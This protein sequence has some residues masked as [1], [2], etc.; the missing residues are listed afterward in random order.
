MLSRLTERLK[1]FIYELE[2]D[3]QIGVA[4]APVSSYLSGG[5]LPAIHWLSSPRGVMWADPFGVERDGRFYIFYEEMVYA[6]NK[7]TINCIILDKQYREIERK[8]IM[9]GPYHMSYPYLIQHDGVDYML[10]ETC[11]ADKL[12]LYRSVKWPYEW[13]EEKVLLNTPCIDTVLFHQAGYWWLVYTK[14]GERDGNEVYYIRRNTDMMDGWETC[15]EQRV[16][17]GRYNSRSGGSVFEAGG[18][19]Y[20][21]TQNCTDSYGQSLVINEI[22]DLTEGSYREEAVLEVRNPS[23]DSYGF[24]TI[25]AMGQLSLVDCRWE[26]RFAKSAGQVVQGLLKKVTG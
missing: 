18:R 8:V 10:P 19:L 14:K 15:A 9:D 2:K 25:S 5:P 12:T 16:D 4:T 7:G 21:V 20:R 11:G 1:Y 23:P 22:K 24:H 26:R 17:G 6:K 13:K 3:W